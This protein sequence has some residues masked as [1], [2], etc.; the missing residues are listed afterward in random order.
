MTERECTDNDFPELA[1]L[2]TMGKEQILELVAA[3]RRRVARGQS[4][5]GAMERQLLEL[6]AKDEG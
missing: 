3:A 1:D 4:D 2:R 5:I 6:E